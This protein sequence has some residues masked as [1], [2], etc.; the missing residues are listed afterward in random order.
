MGHLK[1]S[2]KERADFLLLTTV[3]TKKIK[4]FFDFDNLLITIQFIKYPVML[5][6]SFLFYIYFKNSFILSSFLF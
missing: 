3:I 6:T 2:V 1:I 5:H 4:D